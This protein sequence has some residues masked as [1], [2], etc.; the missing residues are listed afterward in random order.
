MFNF[1]LLF[2]VINT[3]YISIYIYVYIYIF[4]ISFPQVLCYFWLKA[5][6]DAS[7]SDII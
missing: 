7:Q 6:R 5:V 1:F 4:I 3:E 2:A